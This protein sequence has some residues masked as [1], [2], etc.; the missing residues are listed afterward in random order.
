V[1]LDQQEIKMKF[2]KQDLIDIFRDDYDELVYMVEEEGQWISEGKYEYKDII[3]SVL[4][5][6]KFYMLSI[7]RSG[8]YF[9]DWYYDFE[10]WNEEIECMEVISKEVTVTHWILVK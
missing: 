10:D 8:S 1:D 4:N 9:S 2:K 7:S 5:L 6:N 3:F